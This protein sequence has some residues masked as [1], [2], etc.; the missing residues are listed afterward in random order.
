MTGGAGDCAGDVGGDGA[1]G[2]NGTARPQS[3]TASIISYPAFAVEIFT[4]AAAT[5]PSKEIVNAGDAAQSVVSVP[6]KMVVEAA[7]GSISSTC[8]TNGACDRQAFV[9][10]TP[11]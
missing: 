2:G 11:V 10:E 6:A 9:A 3:C 8:V 1:P 5:L 7:P 4:I